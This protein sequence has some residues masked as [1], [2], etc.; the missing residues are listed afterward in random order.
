MIIGVPKENK[1]NEFRVA[2]VPSSV[3]VLTGKGHTVYVEYGAGAGSGFPDKAYIDSG[4][5]MAEK[6]EVYEKAELLYKV[7]E[8]EAAEYNMLRKGQIIFTY[9][10]SNAHL[11]MTKELLS[12]GVI[13]IAYEDVDDDNSEFPLLS[14]MSVLAGKG[15]FLAALYFSQAVHGGTGLLLNRITGVATPRISIIGCGYSGVG[16]AELAASFGNKVIMLDVSS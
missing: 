8:I 2:A 3:S 1:H 13:G 16:A 10:H 5:L 12:R 9:L 14:P 11:E 15:G 6:K 4:A 7:K